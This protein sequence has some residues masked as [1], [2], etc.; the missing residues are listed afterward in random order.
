MSISKTEIAVWAV[1]AVAVAA[2]GAVAFLGMGSTTTTMVIP[3]NAHSAA[4]DEP[5]GVAPEATTGLLPGPAGELGAHP[6][7]ERSGR[8]L[9]TSELRG[10]FVVADFIFTSCAGTCPQM[11][12]KMVDLQTELAGASDVVL[13]SFSVD[14]KRDTPEVL[15]AYAKHYG[16]R[17]EWL[18][19]RAEAD[20][21]AKIGCDEVKLWKDRSEAG[22]HSAQFALLDREGRIR[23][24]YSPLLDEKWLGKLMG[25]IATLRNEPAR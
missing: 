13:A 15:A 21:M 6:V 11:M 5:A 10:K 16:A 17:D 8:A 9:D 23:G 24:Y 20:V 14:P 25:D 12:R 19:L 18:F 3:M 22:M 2:I 7:V 4:T 1:A